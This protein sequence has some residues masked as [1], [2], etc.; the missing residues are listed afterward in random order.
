MLQKLDRDGSTHRCRGDVQ[1]WG[2]WLGA[3]MF[4]AIVLLFA[5]N[6]A[7]KTYSEMI[8][9][10]EAHARSTLNLTTETVDTTPSDDDAP[11]GF[12]IFRVVVTDSSGRLSFDCLYNEAAESVAGM[13]GA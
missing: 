8:D 4:A 5:Q 3:S 1:L 11:D 6:A 7:A 9:D 13:A 12:L 10:C 2:R